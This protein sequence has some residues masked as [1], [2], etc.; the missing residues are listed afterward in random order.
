MRLI[1]ELLFGLSIQPLFFKSHELA[2]P[3]EFGVL[4]AN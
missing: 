3:F 4:G 1:E 2:V